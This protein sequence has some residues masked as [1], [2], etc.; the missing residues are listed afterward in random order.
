[1]RH[2]KYV[3]EL[4]TS[5]EGRRDRLVPLLSQA[6][7]QAQ[8]VAR[9]FPEPAVPVAVVAAPYIPDSVAEQV[10]EFARR[11]APNVAVGVIDSEG[12][13]DFSGYGLE[14]LKAERAASAQVEL[15]VHPPPSL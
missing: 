9:Q 14:E 15:S 8:A 1:A 7:L 10:K 3:I 12:L 2:K 13:R 5:A 6:I 4:K 11:Y